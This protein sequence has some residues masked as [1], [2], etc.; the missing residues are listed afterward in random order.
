MDYRYPFLIE[1]D[2]HLDAVECLQDA[3]ALASLMETVDESDLTAIA[4]L[5]HDPSGFYPLN[6]LIGMIKK[7]VSGALDYI[8]FA[9]S[10]DDPG[11]LFKHIFD[12]IKLTD[13]GE[14]PYC[15]FVGMNLIKRGLPGYQKMKNYLNEFIDDCCLLEPGAKENSFKLYKKFEAYQKTYKPQEA[16][17]E[18]DFY[19]MLEERFNYMKDAEESRLIFWGLKLAPDM[20]EDIKHVEDDRKYKDMKNL[21]NDFLAECCLLETNAK[22]SLF[23]LYKR[24]KAW[25]ELHISQNVISKNEF[26][27]MLA[28]RFNEDPDKDQLVFWGLKLA[29]DIDINHADPENQE[30]REIEKQ[31]TV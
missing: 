24:F 6:R 10:T 8:E 28:E 23:K 9:E 12:H 26:C 13:K 22:E 11:T 25:H 27:N 5:S 14:D 4:G 1:L 15:V 7:N 3:L 29:P 18:N 20:S 21:F 17:S 19:D 30:S 2:H 16:I 31:A